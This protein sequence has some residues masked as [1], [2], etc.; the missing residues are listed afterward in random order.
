MIGHDKWKENDLIKRVTF[1]VK[2]SDLLLKHKET[3]DKFKKDRYP[4][5]SQSNIFS[6]TTD[7]LSVR[8]SYS[9]TYTIEFNEPKAIWPSIHIEFKHDVTL[10]EYLGHV[11]YLVQF[12]SLSLGVPLTP[13]DFKICRLSF[14]DMKAAVSSHS[15]P[16]N[17]S[18]EYVWPEIVFYDSDLWVGGSLVKA[19]DDEELAALKNC[20]FAWVSR[21]ASWRKAS[22]Q[23]T[24]CTSLNG[25]I[26]SDRLLSACKWFEEIP[27]TQSE[28][29]ISNEHIQIISK[30]ASEEA[31]KLGYKDI[32]KRI[33][34]SLKSIKSEANEDRF[35]RL[36]KMVR[37]KFGSSVIDEDIIGY[38]KQAISFRGKSAHGHFSPTDD[39]EF[40]SFTKSIYAME[41]LCFLL[42]TYGLPVNDNGIKRM[43]D[44]PF[45][46]H[47]RLS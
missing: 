41:A 32:N 30:V 6:L 5:E 14:E 22:I 47:Y 20:L 13:S 18:V 23:M 11:C 24:C 15:Y 29:V 16:G 35:T 21:H 46:K 28:K 36:V 3:F 7:T 34:G 43:H 9:A 39:E 40:R 44:N 38:L 26:S 17:Y 8:V 25:E 42:T 1:S 27:L 10:S 2:H 45:I 4:E 31:L 33:S 19:Y 12:L 37:E